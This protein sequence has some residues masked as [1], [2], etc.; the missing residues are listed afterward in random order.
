MLS[1]LPWH[2]LPSGVLD[3]GIPLCRTQPSRPNL[4][5]HPGLGDR[6]RAGAARMLRTRMGVNKREGVRTPRGTR[7]SGPAIESRAKGRV[8]GRGLRGQS[9]HP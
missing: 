4:N 1:I 9:A 3:P 6:T 8:T 5:L 7:R 2:S